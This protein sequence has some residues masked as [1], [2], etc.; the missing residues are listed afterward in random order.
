MFSTALLIAVAVFIYWHAA[1]R[2]T[3][4]AQTDF[5]ANKFA[6]ANAAPIR[7][8]LNNE[9]IPEFRE[10]PDFDE[11]ENRKAEGKLMDLLEDGIYRRSE[12][13]AKNGEEWLVFVKGPSGYSLQRSAA[14]VKEL[15]SVS[16]PGEEKDA[17]VIFK[18]KEK[19][20]LALRNI[21][22]VNVGSV[23][24]LFQRGVWEEGYDQASQEMATGYR[25]TFAIG[26]SEHVLRVSRG[27]T[28]D[29]TKVAVLVLESRGTA[30]ILKY[31][32]HSPDDGRDI[33]G[34]LLWVGDMDRDG[35]L[36][37]YFDEFNEK[38]STGTELHLSSHA[39]GG[40]LVG[41]VAN[42]GLAGC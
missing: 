15:D 33:I 28:Q 34:S 31:A 1:D 17:Q 36:D 42:F 21:S 9:F 12:V 8:P 29:G 37:L 18:V 26:G 35:K 19:P 10:L 41:L 6:A 5:V 20:I 22:N 11:I 40:Q 4:E 13:A 3:A 2:G 16:W 30:Q 14:T 7:E 25:R 39:G 32:P 27:L 23:S 24:T 38:G